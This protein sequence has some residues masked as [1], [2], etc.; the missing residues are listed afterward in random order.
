MWPLVNGVA[1][2]NPDKVVFCLGSD[3]SQQEGNDAEAARLA[4][5]RNLNVKLLIDDNDVTIAGH[6][7]EY[8]KGYDIAKTLGG[9]GL[10]VFTAEGEN[11]DDL[12]RGVAELVTTDGPAAL[13]SKRLMAP[14]VKGI[15]GSSHGHDVVSVKVAIEY[16]EGK[17]YPKTVTDILTGIKGK[18]NPYTCLGSSKEVGANRVEFGEAVCKVLDKTSKEENAKKVMVIDSEQRKQYSYLV[19]A[20]PA[21][22]VTLRALPD[23]K[24][25]TPSI[26]RS[27]SRQVS[28]S[29]A[30]SRPPL[31]SALVA[32]SKE[33]SQPS[34]LSSRCAFQKL[35]WPASTTATF[36]VISLIAVLTRWL[37]TLVISGVSHFFTYA[38][39]C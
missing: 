19:D 8:L 29:A 17:G 1:M 14:G 27:L 21:P 22:Q 12:W 30:I 36:Y 35:P 37:T 7:S 25:F 39:N 13:V 5:A 24:S 2:A 31:V 26:L 4:V 15:E 18:P 6:P 32:I 11:I 10:K 34:P 38:I 33:F 28:W 16:L 20:K 23:S 9:H 3:G